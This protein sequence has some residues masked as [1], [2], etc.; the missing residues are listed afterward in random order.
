M[1]Q[2]HRLASRVVSAALVAM[3][4]LIG[5]S[6]SAQ[7]PMG[8]PAIP[9]ADGVDLAPPT[10][11]AADAKPPTDPAPASAAQ[12]DGSEDVASPPTAARTVPAQLT[13]WEMLRQGGA[14]LWVIM[15]LSVITLVAAV[16]LFLTVTPSREVPPTFVK[17]AMAQLRAEDFRGAY[18]MCEGR[19]EIIAKVLRAGLKASGHDRYVVQEAMESEGERAATALWQRI[20]YLNNV[21]A[22]APLLGLLGTVWGMIGAF[23]AIALDDASVKGVTMAYSVAKAMITTMAGLTLA[24]PALV[25]YYFLRWRVVQVISLVEAQASEMI[26]LLTRSGQDTP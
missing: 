20:S 17:R 11:P 1:N 6:A 2:T 15:A 23:G 3:I 13:L 22:I 8:E 9:P 12:E 19:D 10:P 24:I 5:W 7:Q 18:Q 26:E 16:Y 14:I 4:A 21:G 25:A